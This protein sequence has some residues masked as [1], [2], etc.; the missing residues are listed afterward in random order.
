LSAVLASNDFALRGVK[1]ALG[2]GG[3]GTGN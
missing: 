2:Y 3:P 1:S